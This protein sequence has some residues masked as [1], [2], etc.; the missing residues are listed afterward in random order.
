[1]ADIGL[2]PL[3]PADVSDSGS[4]LMT[5]LTQVSGDINTNDANSFS[6]DLGALMT[7]IANL[8]KRAQGNNQSVAAGIL[9][10]MLGAATQAQAV[11]SRPDMPISSAGSFIQQ[12]SALTDQ[13]KQAVGAQPSPQ[14]WAAKLSGL[15]SNKIALG[16]AAAAVV[17]VSAAWY[18]G[19][20][21]DHRR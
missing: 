4:D 3:T 11:T 21:G 17:G 13:L 8:L 14:G 10:N 6:S 18:G 5:N 1:M 16:A 2:S 20:L 9:S 12:I 7:S 19:L 15:L